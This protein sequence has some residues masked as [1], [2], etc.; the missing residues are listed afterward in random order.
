MS[1]VFLCETSDIPTNG[2]KG[3]NLS[4][5][6]DNGSQ[7]IFVVNRDE[8]YF[9]Y[10]NTCPHTGAS[11]NWQPDVFLDYDNF[12]I[13]CAIHAARFEV[14]SGL[15]VWGPCANQSLK[16]CELTIIDNKVYLTDYSK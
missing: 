13:Q 8:Q 6:A 2:C 5:P 15:C 14:K 11:L 9:A 10:K 16:K 3:F 12:Y 4:D 7:D 1:Q